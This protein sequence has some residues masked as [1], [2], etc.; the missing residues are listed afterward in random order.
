MNCSV[1][2]LEGKVLLVQ[3]LLYKVNLLTWN[4]VAKTFFKILCNMD[5]VDRE[6]C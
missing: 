1:A 2:G 6:G 4:M 3:C 5:H